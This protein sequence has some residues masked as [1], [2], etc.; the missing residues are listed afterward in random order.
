MLSCCEEKAKHAE[1][2]GQRNLPTA[3]SKG[4]LEDAARTTND[5]NLTDNSISPFYYGDSSDLDREDRSEPE[6]PVEL[7]RVLFHVRPPFIQPNEKII[8]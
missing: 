5:Q 1:M 2:V 6:L 8:P 3:A 4:D 7:K